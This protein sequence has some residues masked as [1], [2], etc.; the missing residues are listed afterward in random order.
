MAKGVAIKFKSYG[1]SVNHLLRVIKLDKELQKHNNIVLK[2]FLMSSGKIHT[3]VEFVES[4]LLYCLQHKPVDA[5]VFIA[6]GSDGED[7]LDLFEKMGYKKLAEKYSIGLIDLN[8]CEYEEIRDGDFLKFESIFYPKILLD[9][10]VISLPKIALDDELEMIGS[11]SNMVGAFPSQFYKGF[12][13]KKK[14]KLRKWNMKYTI[15]D[16][17]RC[18]MPDFSIVD[19]SEQGNILAGFAIEMDKQASVLLGKSPSAISHL[20]LAMQS[21]P[22]KPVKKEASEVENNSQ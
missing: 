4:V 1:E 11:L 8:E 3:P 16:V 18:K 7:T 2:P 19:A 15:H 22:D 6:E 20:S 5:R 14:T 12:L 9:S 10:F 17:L 13:T 21:F